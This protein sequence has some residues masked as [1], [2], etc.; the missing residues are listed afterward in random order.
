MPTLALPCFLN[1]ILDP[2]PE[3]V[4]GLE[5]DLERFLA[6]VYCLRG[7]SLKCDQTQRGHAYSL[8]GP[9][10]MLRPAKI[11]GYCLFLMSQTNDQTHIGPGSGLLPL[12]S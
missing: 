9:R 3:E 1:P 8:R 4:P 10:L 12:R 6:L 11:L 7:S 2:L 5:L